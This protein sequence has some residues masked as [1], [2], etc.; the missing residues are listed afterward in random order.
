MVAWGP[1]TQPAS[2]SLSVRHT[3]TVDAQRGPTNQLTFMPQALT[4]FILLPQEL[5]PQTVKGQ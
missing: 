3:L 2:C 1:L 5:Y 4:S